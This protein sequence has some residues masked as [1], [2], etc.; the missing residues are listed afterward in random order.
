MKPTDI[1]PTSP[2]ATVPGRFAGKVLLVTGAAIGSIGGCTAIRAAREGARVACVD[3]KDPRNAG[4]GGRNPPAGG[5][6]FALPA[7]SDA[8]S[9]GRSNGDRG[10]AP[11]T[12]VST[13]C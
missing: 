9:R 5:E 11:A 2:D 3:I 8:T 12:A 7:D 6:A 13:S 10:R 1:R 4:H